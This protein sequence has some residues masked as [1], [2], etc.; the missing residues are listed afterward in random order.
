MKILLS[1]HEKYLLDEL[2][3]MVLQR[4][5]K[6]HLTTISNSK[7]PVVFQCIISVCRWDHEL[8]LYVLVVLERCVAFIFA[9]PLVITSHR[10]S[11]TL[12]KVSW[13]VENICQHATKARSTECSAILNHCIHPFLR[14]TTWILMVRFCSC[15][16][17]LRGIRCV[18][19]PPN[20][21]SWETCTPYFRRS[22]WSDGSHRIHLLIKES[23]HRLYRQQ[24]KIH[25]DIWILM[26]EEDQE[27]YSTQQN[28]KLLGDKCN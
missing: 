4:T 9:C 3:R 24:K 2:L 22:L 17:H 11:W 7:Q 15:Y 27:T 18:L 19:S 20:A 16:H 8:F 1:T 5:T 6:R 10:R 23:I 25:Q 28:Y 14:L 12:I 21:L 13:E 26:N